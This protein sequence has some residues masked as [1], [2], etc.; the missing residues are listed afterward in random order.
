MP[1]TVYPSNTEQQPQKWQW[2]EAARHRF[3]IIR[4]M[5]EVVDRAK[6]WLDRLGT[7]AGNQFTLMLDQVE[8][9]SRDPNQPLT[10]AQE[11]WDG[12]I[13]L[14]KTGAPREEIQK[15]FEAFEQLRDDQYGVKNGN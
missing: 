10:P 3:H 9:G 12:A 14:I 15:Q 8:K 2:P 11:A 13:N 5:P 7:E 6:S 1:D 4:D